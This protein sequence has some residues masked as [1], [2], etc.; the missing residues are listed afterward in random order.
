[1]CFRKS[2]LTSAGDQAEDKVRKPTEKEATR[3]AA[4]HGAPKR[5][6]KSDCHPAA[7]RLQALRERNLSRVI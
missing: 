4:D 2:D 6:F 3:K 5:D 7:G 1:M